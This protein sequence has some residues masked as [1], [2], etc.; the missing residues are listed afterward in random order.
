MNGRPS[1]SENPIPIPSSSHPANFPVSTLDI[2]Y[3]YDYSYGNPTGRA[4]GIGYLQELLARLMDQY[5]PSSNSSVNSTLDDNETTFPLNE[6]F[7]VDFSHD[8]IIISVLTA[9]SMDYFNDPPSLN[10]VPPNPHR[11]FILSHLTPFGARLITEVIGCASPDPSPV[12]YSRTQYTPTQYGYDPSNASNKFIR[13][14]LNNGILPLDSIRGGACGDATSGRT[15]GLCEMGAFLESQKD[16][17]TRANYDFSCFGNYTINNAENPGANYDGAAT[18]NQGKVE[19][20]REGGTEVV[21]DILN[22][23][24]N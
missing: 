22:I 14:R 13:M 23:V 6:P 4:Q 8:D 21:V 5:I 19:G 20:Q 2:E 16:S 12:E 3:F 1:K 11:N 17:Y 15:D 10:Q 7:Y 24:V 18:E 9:M